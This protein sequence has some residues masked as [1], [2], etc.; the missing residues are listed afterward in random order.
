VHG[1]S[2]T[3]TNL[4][5]KAGTF[6]VYLIPETLRLTNLGDI[7]VGGHVNFEIDRRTQAIVDTVVWYMEEHSDEMLR[8]LRKPA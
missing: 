7:K 1:A 3:V 2:L 5:R 8:Q 6:E 4:D